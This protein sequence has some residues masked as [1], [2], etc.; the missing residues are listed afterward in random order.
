MSSHSPH[1]PHGP[2]RST[3]SPL[4]K[5]LLRGAFDALTEPS[6]SRSSSP[7][8]RGEYSSTSRR[9]RDGDD[10]TR[11][12]RQHSGTYTR[13]S[14]S[15]PDELKDM[16]GKAA[17]ELS[18]L[19]SRFEGRLRERRN[20]SSGMVSAG[21]RQFQNDEDRFEVLSDDEGGTPEGEAYS[22]GHHNEH[23]SARPRAG[24]ADEYFNP[25]GGIYG[26][27]THGQSQPA[28]TPQLSNVQPKPK[29]SSTS[30]SKAIRKAGGD[31][32]QN[33]PALL[34]RAGWLL[35]ILQAQQRRSGTM[36]LVSSYGALLMAL[37]VAVE[38]FR[39][40]KERKAVEREGVRSTGRER[41]GDRGTN[42]ERQR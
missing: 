32:L 33:L 19:V 5:G 41:D 8:H 6:S 12:Y 36:S 28:V 31:L 39:Q 16:L 35:R 21:P 27:T 24:L 17:V 10:Y 34:D 26:K 11:E 23:G 30:A 22:R 9:H 25:P 1:R 37:N 4:L 40:Y 18:R 38:L 13:T 3:T 29:R 42:R 7:R 14:T 20:G 2:S 15:S